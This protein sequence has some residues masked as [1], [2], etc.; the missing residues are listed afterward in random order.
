MQ[1]YI[2]VYNNFISLLTDVT[3]ASEGGDFAYFH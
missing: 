1:S 2:C 3:K